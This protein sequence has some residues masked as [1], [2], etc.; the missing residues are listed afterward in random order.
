[1]A[2]VNPAQPDEE[3][4]DMQM[5]RLLFDALAD[6]LSKAD[7]GTMAVKFCLVLEV[8]DRDGDRSLWTAA[9]PD[10]KAWDTVGMLQHALHIQMAQT[11][12]FTID[13]LR[14]E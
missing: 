6:V 12:A 10:V 9:G 11:T 7:P 5:E 14:G 2:R 13:E 1:M 8:I 4:Q 3:P